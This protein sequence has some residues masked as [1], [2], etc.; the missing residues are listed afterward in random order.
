MY[1]ASSLSPAFFYQTVF[2]PSFRE[3]LQT[4]SSLS[5]LPTV[6]PA[7]LL[8]R[9]LIPP[10]FLVEMISKSFPIQA[11]VALLILTSSLTSPVNAAAIAR[12]RQ[13]LFLVLIDGE[14]VF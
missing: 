8:L 10:Y 3:Y 2:I 4:S 13:F 1:K 14:Y 6:P 9:A 11:F 5:F 7:P 12:G